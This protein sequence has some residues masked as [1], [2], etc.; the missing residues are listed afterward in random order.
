[1]NFGA[2]LL[3][4]LRPCALLSNLA[5]TIINATFDFAAYTTSLVLGE[6]R[7]EVVNRLCGV[8]LKRGRKF[9]LVELKPLRLFRFGLLVLTEKCKLAGGELSTLFC[10]ESTLF[11]FG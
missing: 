4:A 11:R 9:V 1:M 2:V 10:R 7:Y 6:I 3:E 5:E 8:F